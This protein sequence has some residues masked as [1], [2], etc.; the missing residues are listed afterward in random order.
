MLPAAARTGAEVEKDGRARGRVPSLSW[1]T[2]GRMLVAL[3]NMLVEMSMSMSVTS[4]GRGRIVHPLAIR[5]SNKS[6]RK[7]WVISVGNLGA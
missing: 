5:P 3:L 1:E 7:S 4:W 6:S 2:R